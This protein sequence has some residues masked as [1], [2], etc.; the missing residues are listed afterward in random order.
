[1]ITKTN[2]A[3]AAITASFSLWARNTR[4]LPLFVD[5][6]DRVCDGGARGPVAVD[7]VRMVGIAEGNAADHAA[8]VA[9]VEVAADQSRVPRQ[10]RLRNRSK[11][12][13]LRR[14]HE[15]ADIGAAIDRT[16]D[17]ERLGR[18]NDRHMRRAEE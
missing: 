12:Q 10:R 13:C 9:E 11:S 17:A 2:P 18:V 7:P 4:S 14:Q 5:E 6:G 1:M 15:I 16:V 3:A 8:I